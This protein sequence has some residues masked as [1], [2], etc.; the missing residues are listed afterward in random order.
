LGQKLTASSGSSSPQFEQN[1]A[2]SWGSSAPHSGQKLAATSD[3]CAPQ[4]GQDSS[5]CCSWVCSSV[6]A[7]FSLAAGVSFCVG[8]IPLRAEDKAHLLL[9]TS[10]FVVVGALARWMA[11]GRNLCEGA[12]AAAA[13]I[14][15]DVLEPAT[16]YPRRYPFS[17]ARE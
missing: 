9:A 4:F 17:A 16:Q 1:L 5:C 13:A 10:A 15:H 8:Y 12:M 7:L 2:V 11:R 3:S 6:N 14:F